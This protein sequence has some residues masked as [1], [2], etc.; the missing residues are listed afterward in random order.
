MASPRTFPVPLD[1]LTRQQ[2]R[3]LANRGHDVSPYKGPPPM[4]TELAA[5][6]KAIAFWKRPILAPEPLHIYLAGPMTGIPEFNF[7]AFH[8]KTAALRDLGHTVFSPAERDLEK[9]R[10]FQVNNPGGDIE[11]AVSHGFSLRAAMADDLAWICSYADAIYMLAGWEHSAGARA[12][13]ALASCLR[14]KFFYETPE[15]TP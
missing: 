12:E 11:L 5:A 14:L 10:D 15:N 13:W 1:M 2:K 8:R 3:Y 7:P 9:D 6:A 4:T